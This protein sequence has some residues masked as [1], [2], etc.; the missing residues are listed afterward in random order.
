MNFAQK[1]ERSLS[2][3]L[4]QKDNNKVSTIVYYME[5]HGEIMLKEAETISGQCQCLCI[6]VSII[7]AK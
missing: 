2:E 6:R 5:K 4:T 3:V 7:F 1:N